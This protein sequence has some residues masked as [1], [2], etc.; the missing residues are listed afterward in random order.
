MPELKKNRRHCIDG[1][2]TGLSF[3]GSFSEKMNERGGEIYD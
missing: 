2:L 1:A 3:L